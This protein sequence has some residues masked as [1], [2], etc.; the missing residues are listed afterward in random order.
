M[1]LWLN[2]AISCPGVGVF[3]NDLDIINVERIRK[4]N[5]STYHNY[6]VVSVASFQLR[7][8]SIKE[9]KRVRGYDAVISKMPMHTP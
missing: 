2:W 1:F 7:Y 5:N 4:M 6:R 8:L 3:N 9:N